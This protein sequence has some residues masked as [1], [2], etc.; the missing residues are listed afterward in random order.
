MAGRATNKLSVAKIR[1]L[2]KKGRY[3]DGNGLYLQVSEWKTKSW[4]YRYQ[5]RGKRTEMG[6]GSLKDYS[7]AQARNRARECRMLVIEGIDPKLHREA[8]R[9]NLH[10]IQGWTFSKCAEAYIEAHSPQWSNPKHIAQ[11]RSTLTTYASP[12]FGNL[13]VQQIDAALVMRVI[14]PIW[15]TKTETASRVRGRIE[16]VLAWAIVN[17]YRDQPNPAVWRNNLDQLLPAKSKVMTVKHHEALPYAEISTF[18]EGLSQVESVSAKALTFMILTGLRT[19]EI[20]QASWDQIDLDN[21]IWTVPANVMKSRRIHRVPLSDQ[22]VSLLNNLPKLNGWLFPSNQSG[23]HIGE[24]AMHKL[25]RKRLKRLDITVHGFR[26]TFR[27]WVAELTKYPR[28]VAEAALA[29]VNSDKVEAAYQRGDL[30]E[31]RR[32]LMQDWANY[33]FTQDDNVVAI[34]I[35][36]AN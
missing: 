20:I 7:L 4:I 35:P 6:L 22:A 8:A 13:P 9:H 21:K 2:N 17:E 28:E 18:M 26:S 23:K 19:G 32:E 25:V 5:I 14:E 29:H 1:S 3:P 33:V 30:L 12:V 15:L 11:W 10:E 36:Q 34:P 24:A 16:K 27:D 31:K